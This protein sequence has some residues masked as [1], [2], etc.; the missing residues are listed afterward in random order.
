MFDYF[1][2][3]SRNVHHVC[4]K[5][6]RTKRLHN[7][8]QSVDLAFH[9]RS[10]VRPKHDYFLTYNISDSIKLS[11]YIKIWHDGRLVDALHTHARFD[12]LD[13]DLDARLQCVG[14]GKTN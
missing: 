9:S 12:D 8:C 3:Y 13:I 7:H 11:S 5:Y 14:K 1:R 2:N 10:Q 4:C 6:S